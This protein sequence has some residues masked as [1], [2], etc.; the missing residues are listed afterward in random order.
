MDF[1]LCDKYKHKKLFITIINNINSYH[2]INRLNRPT[3]KKL[4]DLQYA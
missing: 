1:D 2:R 4:P 3:R